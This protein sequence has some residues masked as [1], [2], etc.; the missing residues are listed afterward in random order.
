MTDII[1][2]SFNRPYYLDRCLHSIY[3]L[4]S[5]AFRITVLDDGTPP[6]Y[7]EKIQSSFPEIIIRRS[8][9]YEEKVRAI[10]AHVKGQAPFQ[11]FQ[12]PVDLWTAQV[13]SA[14]QVFLLLEDDIWLT[15]KVDLA[16]LRSQM[17]QHHVVVAK[18]GWSGN[19]NVNQGK[20]SVLSDALESIEPKL[21]VASS[22]MFE[23]I[24][25]NKYKVRSLLYRLGFVND[26]FNLP[27]YAMYAVAAA[28]F[29]KSYWL[30]LWENAGQRVNETLQLNKA[31]H[32]KNSHPGD[33]F[34]KS[35]QE[36]CKTSYIS[37]ATNNFEG[38]NL[39][40]IV[41]NHH[42]NEAWLS[43]QLD[44]MNNFPRDFDV[45]YLQ[46]LLKTVADKRYSAEGWNQWIT[47]FKNQYINLGCDVE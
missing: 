47:R 40:M 13:A 24:A 28:M 5:G 17:E 3:Q 6:A 4:V 30:S 10:E 25:L 8:A 43:G 33:A 1:I 45:S 46:G 23:A 39:D 14:S 2:K 18:I 44:P 11:S 12:I 7:L 36:L 27:Y 32:W 19:K 34:G 29:D 37:S 21:P 35:R 31:L 41:L 20:I 22:V 42:L 15:E 38:V 26:E 9:L 16:Q